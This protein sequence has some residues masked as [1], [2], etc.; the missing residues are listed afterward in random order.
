MAKHINY[1]SLDRVI[2]KLYR[3]LGLEEI[4]EVDIV[5]WTGEALEA[6]GSLNYLEEA[7]AFI[8]ISNHQGELPTGLQSIIQVARNNKWVK[9]EK[10]CTPANIICDSTDEEIIS[11]QGC[12]CNTPTMPVLLDCHGNFIDD[13]EVA[14]YR[15]YFDLRYEYHGWVNSKYY[16]HSFTPVRLSTHTFFN[17]IVCAEDNSKGLYDNC[18][19]EYT[20]VQDKIRTSFK[21]GQVAIAFYR[22]MLDPDTGYPVI[23]DEYSTL[24]AITAYITMKYMARMWYLGKEGYGDKMQKAEMDWQWYCKQAKNTNFLPYGVDEYQNIADMKRGLLPSK[25]KYYGFFGK[26]NRPQSGEWKNTTGL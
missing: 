18:T 13:V 11:N 5:E 20:I 3:D 15:P 25:D 9:E 4:S 23:P 26:L 7:V 12:G 21:D 1:T 8:E 24:Q 14:Y 19:D 17:S 16:E 22:Q 6:I 10:S 2:S